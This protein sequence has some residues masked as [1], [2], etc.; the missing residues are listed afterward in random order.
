MKAQPKDAPFYWMWTDRA[1]EIASLRADYHTVVVPPVDLTPLGKV[2][3]DDF[4]IGKLFHEDIVKAIGA[5]PAPGLQVADDPGSGAF[6]VQA[7]I[8]DLTATKAAL[9]AVTSVAGFFIPGAALVSTAISAGAGAAAGAA[10]KGD[11][12]VGIQIK[13]SVNNEILLE[14]ADYRDDES[15]LLFDAK[16]FSQYGHTRESLAQWANAVPWLFDRGVK[17][18]RRDSLSLVKIW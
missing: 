13:N 11:C 2:S 8:L 7:A 3:E 15:A 6:V 12:A 17:V 14:A 1:P 9:N 10:A 4:A 5:N 16:S 18:G